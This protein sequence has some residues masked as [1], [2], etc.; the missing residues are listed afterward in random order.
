MAQA[1]QQVTVENAQ[2][3]MAINKRA[4]DLDVKEIRLQSREQ[5]LALKEQLGKQ[6]RQMEDEHKARIADVDRKGMD[7]E[8]QHQEKMDGVTQ[9]ENELTLKD[10]AKTMT[11]ELEKKAAVAEERVAA[12]DAVAK[13]VES[14]HSELKEALKEVKD[15]Q[16]QTQKLIEMVADIVKRPRKSTLVRDP[17]TGKAVSAVSEVT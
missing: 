2:K 8:R 7:M 3:E 13:E 11:G 17:K 14:A 15:L 5:E 16:A 6:A 10:Q 12:H 4:A 1:K 9:R